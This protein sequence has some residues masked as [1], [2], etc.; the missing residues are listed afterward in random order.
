MP[1]PPKYW[2]RRILDATE[3]G[4]TIVLTSAEMTPSDRDA[5]YKA[6]RRLAQLGLIQLVTEKVDGR[7]RVV[8]YPPTADTPPQRRVVAQDGRVWRRPMPETRIPHMGPE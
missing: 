1:R 8:A 3:E 2:Q 4:E 7:N 6:A 5:T